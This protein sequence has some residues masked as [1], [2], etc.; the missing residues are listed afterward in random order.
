MRVLTVARLELLFRVDEEVG[1]EVGITVL[2][3]QPA[4]DRRVVGLGMTKRLERQSSA[5]RFGHLSLV[6]FESCEH[7]RIVVWIDDD[8]NAGMVLGCCPNHAGATDVDHLHDFGRRAVIID[9][10]LFGGG[11]FFAVASRSGA[12]SGAHLRYSQG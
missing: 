11:V 6:V 7:L 1:V 4:G 2:L 9:S 10:K 8:D 5:Q 3:V 12:G